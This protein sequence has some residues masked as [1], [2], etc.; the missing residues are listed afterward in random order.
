MASFPTSQPAGSEKPFYDD[1]ND[2][3]QTDEHPNVTEVDSGERK[4]ILRK[5]DSHL[6]P[7]VTLL[8]L[9]SFL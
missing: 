9:L 8:Y 4:R 3:A 6:L 2:I 5:L 1:E 7:I